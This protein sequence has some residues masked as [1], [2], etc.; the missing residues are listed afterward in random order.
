MA[1]ITGAQLVALVNT[2]GFAGASEYMHAL[3]SWLKEG[4]QVVGQF[5]RA[6]KSLDR[7]LTDADKTAIRA[8][9]AAWLAREPVASEYVQAD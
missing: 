6:S 8:K 5:A 3:G 9:A 2:N 7:P 1:L 4:S